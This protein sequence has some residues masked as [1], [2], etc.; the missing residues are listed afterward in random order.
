MG[1]FRHR[2]AHAFLPPHALLPP[3]ASTA[4][5]SQKLSKITLLAWQLIHSRGGAVLVTPLNPSPSC[6]R[7]YCSP[8]LPSSGQHP[9]RPRLTTQSEPRTNAR[10]NHQSPLAARHLRRL[11]RKRKK[12]TTSRDGTHLEPVPFLRRRRHGRSVPEPRHRPL[13]RPLGLR[14]LGLVESPHPADAHHVPPAPNTGND[15]RRRRRRQQEQ[16]GVKL[17]G[18]RPHK[19]KLE[20]CSLL[21]SW[22][23]IKSTSFRAKTKNNADRRVRLPC[24]MYTG[25]RLAKNTPTGRE[26]GGGLEERQDR[27][28]LLERSGGMHANAGTATRTHSSAHAA[29]LL[30][31][32]V[33]HR[34]HTAW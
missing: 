15:E 2:V 7:L 28:R 22:T 16:E 26:D 19:A 3:H 27:P 30:F 4:H 34:G 9:T 1:Y 14:R 23:F 5:V 24:C 6:R 32:P 21:Y 17:L 25:T 11:F 12:A 29:F 8:T 33:R 20:V 13:P 18:I 10:Q 31:C